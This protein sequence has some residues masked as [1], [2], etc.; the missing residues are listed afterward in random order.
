MYNTNMATE[1]ISEVGAT[2]GAI[3]VDSWNFLWRS[4]F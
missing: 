1:L 2:Q 4:I 3:H